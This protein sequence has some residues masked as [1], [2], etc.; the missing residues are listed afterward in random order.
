MSSWKDALNQRLTNQ[1]LLTSLDKFKTLSVCMGELCWHWM[2]NFWYMALH[3]GPFKVLQFFK[4]LEKSKR[5]TLLCQR[6]F[7]KYFYKIEI[8]ALNIWS[9]ETLLEFWRISPVDGIGLTKTILHAFY[10]VVSKYATFYWIAFALKSGFVLKFMIFCKIY[11]MTTCQELKSQFQ[12][13]NV[14]NWTL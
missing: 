11:Q 4:F 6:K 7:L 13:K 9:F 2:H 5:G 12:W 14:K 10:W 8:W 3:C 1:H